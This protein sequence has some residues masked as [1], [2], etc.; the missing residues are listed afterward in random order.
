MTDDKIRLRIRAVPTPEA[1]H[2]H[3]DTGQLKRELAGKGNAYL[4]IAGIVIS[5]KALRDWLGAAF[6]GPNGKSSIKNA[7][8][9]TCTITYDG[10]RFQELHGFFRGELMEHEDYKI[11]TGQSSYSWPWGR[12]WE[13]TGENP[14]YRGKYG[15]HL[16]IYYKS[17]GVTVRS[18]FKHIRESNRRP[19]WPIYQIQYE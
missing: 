6:V 5:V 15:A 14:E 8:P 13:V 18:R 3:F 4:E 1:W 16:T 7:G 11:L 9:G 2:V 10:E 19:A 17:D 12:E